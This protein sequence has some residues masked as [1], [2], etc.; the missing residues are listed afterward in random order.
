MLKVAFLIL[1]LSTLIAT[2][3]AAEPPSNEPSVV[4]PP[5]PAYTDRNCMLHYMIPA[6]ISRDAQKAVL[7]LSD[8]LTE[9]TDQRCVPFLHRFTKKVRWDWFKRRCKGATD[10]EVSQVLNSA[11]SDKVFC[12]KRADGAYD[13]YSMKRIRNFVVD[14]LSKSGRCD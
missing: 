12:R 6:M 1:A 2:S 8:A 3:F 11:N 9:S 14:E 10:A 13:L 4:C 7:L 5:I